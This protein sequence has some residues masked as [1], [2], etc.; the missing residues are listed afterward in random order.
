MAPGSSSDSA[1]QPDA[2][3]GLVVEFVE[4]IPG[5]PQERQFLFSAIDPEGVLFTLRSLSTPS[6]RFVVIPPA[7]FFPDYQPEVSVADVA[8][9]GL[10]EDAELQVLVIVSVRDGLADA[11][12]NLLA[13]IVLVAESGQALQIV[14]NDPTLPLRAPLV[15]AAS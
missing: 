3:R 11:T 14:L 15:A 8:S 4:P 7:A 1:V 2:A 9:L 12:A 10:G 13:P 6:L 5:F